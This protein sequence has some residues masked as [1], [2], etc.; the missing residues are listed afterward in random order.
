LRE[1]TKNIQTRRSNKAKYALTGAVMR[2][3]SSI[4]T[5]FWA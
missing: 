4:L 2:G 3:Y 5:N 1:K